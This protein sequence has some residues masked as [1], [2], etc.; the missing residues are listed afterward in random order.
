MKLV[1]RDSIHNE[2][3][4]I[5]VMASRQTGDKSLPKLMQRNFT[6][7]ARHLAFMS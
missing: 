1:P 5:Q 7:Y 4:L 3:A 6:A 2:F